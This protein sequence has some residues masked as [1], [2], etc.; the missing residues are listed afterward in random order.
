MPFVGG[1]GSLPLGGPGTW[2]SETV[3]NPAARAFQAR[4]TNVAEGWAYRVENAAGA[5]NFDGVTRYGNDFV[6]LDA[7]SDYSFLL[8]SDGRLQPWARTT[9]TEDVAKVASQVQ[10]AN[11]VPIEYLVGNEGTRAYWQLVFDQAGAGEDLLRIG[12]AP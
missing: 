7:K 8:R 9:F 10:I 6:L 11:G 1:G 12:V 5:H 2:V 3:G 4:A